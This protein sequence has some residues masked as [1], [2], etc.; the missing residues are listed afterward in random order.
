[1]GY[2]LLCDC[3]AEE[4]TVLQYPTYRPPHGLHG[5]KVRDDEKIEWLL[6]I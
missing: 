1:M 3:G 5:L 4:Q 2:G 6:N